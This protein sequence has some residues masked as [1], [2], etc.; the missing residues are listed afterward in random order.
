MMLGLHPL[1]R[2]KRESGVQIETSAFK[3]VSTIK[4]VV[5][6]PP[7]LKTKTTANTAAVVNEEVIMDSDN[8]SERTTNSASRAFDKHCTA[9]TCGGELI[10]GAIW[11]KHVECKHCDGFVSFKVSIG[12]M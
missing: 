4:K 9:G 5:K 12:D 10:S 1:R 6:P 2:L 7:K 3:V 8:E 11:A